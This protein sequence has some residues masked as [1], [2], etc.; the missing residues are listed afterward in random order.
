[1]GWD[2]RLERW[3]VG[4]RAAVLN[5]VFV[6]LSNAGRAGAIWLVIA[7][8]IGLLRRHG[9]VL[10]WT[11]VADGAGE[12]VSDVLKDVIPRA[13]P[14]LHPLVAVPSTNSF[15]SGHGTVSFACATV[16][17][18]F[19]PRL[20]VPLYLLAAAVSWSRVYAGVHWPTDEL[21][22][23]LLGVALGYAVLKALPR[24]EAVRRRR[25]RRRR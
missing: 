21:A 24:L 12:L 22:G 5:H 2:H 4:H 17:A 9:R 7:F 6:W 11:L 16:I 14:H 25:R 13:R 23:A 10:V 15:P 19:A 8:A 3:Q 20:R 1:V 18:A